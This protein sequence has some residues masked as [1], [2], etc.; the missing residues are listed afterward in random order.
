MTT[1]DIK[2]ATKDGIYLNGY[3]VNI[4]YDKLMKLNGKRVR[5]SGKVTIVKGLKHYNDGEI[6]QGRQED[7]KHILRPK[8]KIIDN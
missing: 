3:V 8:I 4:S 7:T 5:I 1:I 2:Q 6:R